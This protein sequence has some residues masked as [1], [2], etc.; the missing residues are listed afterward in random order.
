MKTTIAILAILLTL[1][2]SAFTISGRQYDA[3]VTPAELH[4]IRCVYAVWL[5]RWGVGSKPSGKESASTMMHFIGMG[6]W[7]K[8]MPDERRLLN[9]VDLAV[10]TRVRSETK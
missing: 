4:A 5:P 1:E 8:L 6:R 9:A 10:M 7:L 2:V 3:A